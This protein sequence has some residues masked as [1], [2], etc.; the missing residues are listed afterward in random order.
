MGRYQTTAYPEVRF[1]CLQTLA[2]AC[3][4]HLPALTPDDATALRGA[5]ASW[6]HEASTRADPPI[7]AFIKNKLA[8]V[9]ALLV[10]HEYP[11]RWPTFFHDLVALLASGGPAAPDVFCRVL[12]AVDDEIISTGDT[13]RPRGAAGDPTHAV[14]PSVRVKDALRADSDALPKLAES[15]RAMIAYGSS[16]GGGD[17]TVAVA[18]AAASTARRYVEWMDVSLFTGDGFVAAAMGLLGSGDATLRAAGADFLTALTSKGMEHAAKVEM[19]GRLGLVGVCRQLQAMAASAAASGTDDADQT[20]ETSAAQL[21]AAVGNELFGC[22]RVAA[23]AAAADATEPHPAPP[24]RATCDAAAAMI[25]ELMPVGVAH[26]RSD[27]EQTVMAALPLCAA[28]VNRVKDLGS[29]A[30]P[31]AETTLRAVVDAVI[32]RSAFPEDAAGGG[33]GVGAGAGVDFSRGEDKYTLEAEQEV[34][35]TRQELAVLFRAVSRLSPALALD[36]VRGA[37]V[38]A[39]P[40]PPAPPARWQTVETALAAL[41]LVGEGAD[42]PAVKPG[43]EGPSPLGELV[44]FLLSRWGAGGDGGNPAGG[45]GVPA[46]A[47]RLVA[48]AFLDLCVR[49]HLAVA[50]DHGRLLAPALAAFL[51]ARGMRHPSPEVSRRACYLFCRFVKPLRGQIAPRL[52]EVL[53]ALEEIMERASDAAGGGVGGGAGGT[54]GGTGGAMATAGGDD[55][56]YVFEAVGSLLGADEVPEA[57]QAQWLEAASARL[58]RRIE[59]ARAAGDAAQAQHV[60]VAMANVTKGF[61]QRVATETRPR[62][63]EILRAGLEPALGCLATWPRDPLVRQRVVAYF[64]RMVQCVGPSAFPYASPL[65]EHMRASGSSADLRE[66]LILVNQLMAT[67]KADLAPFVAGTL[68]ALTRQTAAALAPL[69]DANGAARGILGLTGEGLDALAVDGTS[70]AAAAAAAAAGV[71]ANNTEEV[72]EA[73]ELEKMYM[74]HVHGVATN[75]LASVL[76]ASSPPALPATRDVVLASLARWASSHPSATSRKMSLQALTK[77]AQ[78]WIPTPAEMAAGAPPEG[79]PGFRRFAAETI[80]GECCVR[81]V[82]RG[83][84]DPRD[85]ACAAAINEAVNFQRALLERCGREFEVHLKENLLA[86][87]GIDAAG[88]E[89]YVRAVTSTSQTAQRDARAFL[90]ECQRVVAAKCPGLAKRPCAKS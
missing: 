47:H 8:Q 84:L 44:A 1:W 26:L 87:M 55:R 17:A 12:D 68:P 30:A 6:V 28:Y 76:A 41:H 85:A 57:S 51:D 75:G 38:A 54:G 43:A 67:F 10:R 90:A 25:D 53:A 5:V 64:Q 3:R 89:A 19:I 81:A 77:F 63:G 78:A 58:R 83:D 7:P 40:A 46:A 24:P 49:Y 50:R 18:A 45:G 79:V 69:A 15:W 21:A 52:A 11:S 20:S 73:R 42:D 29:G 34:T 37:L 61:T 33:E 2:D 71:D 14:A 39:L 70:A 48:S 16:P 82:L 56:L 4:D 65:V 22:L 13:L 80:A 62:V 72:R 74:S 35:A 31:A 32:S 23:A 88:G 36:A 86:P 59:A 66:C 27:D 9:T 60:V